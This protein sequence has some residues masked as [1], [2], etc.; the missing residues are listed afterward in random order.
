MA[1]DPVS[2]G[3]LVA[4]ESVRAGFPS[5]AQ[6]Y[7]F[8]DLDLNEHLIRDKA[9]TFVVRV[10]GDSM[11]GVIASGDEVI[12]DRSVTPQPGHIVIAVL[13]GELTVK[14]LLRRG[15]GVV[16]H[17]ENPTYPDVRVAEL[18]DLSVWGVVTWI[19]HRA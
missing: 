18:S 16:L 7:F 5:P 10:V 4:A 13:D 2:G 6:D 12:V 17:A 11:L 19:L 1:A 8:G 15:D 9:S 14:R 3:V